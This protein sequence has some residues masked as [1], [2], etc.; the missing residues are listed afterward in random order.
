[1]RY[2][3]IIFDCDGTLIDT[4]EGIANAMNQAL[5]EHGFP[6]A[7]VEQYRNMVGW[8]LVRL[9][10]LALPEQAQTKET[11]TA[12]AARAQ[13]L[14]EEQPPSLSK[15]YPGIRELVALLADHKTPKNKRIYTAVLSNKEDTVLRRLMDEHFGPNA[16]DVVCGLHPGIAPK[17]DPQAVWEIL[18]EWGKNPHDTIFMGDSEIDMETARN[19][20]CYP[21]GVSW[22]FRSRAAL[23]QAGAARIIDRPDELWELVSRQ[24]VH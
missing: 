23:E 21:L 22:G 16:F 2:R 14:M 11:I 15:P 13:Q 10:E 19:S 24:P 12:V 3:C 18:T 1:M 7:P 6:A 17:P 5:G 9:A 8:G 20:G 4:L